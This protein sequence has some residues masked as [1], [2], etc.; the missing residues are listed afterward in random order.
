MGCFDH[1]YR[2]FGNLIVLKSSDRSCYKLFENC[3]V[4]CFAMSFTVGHALVLDSVLRPGAADCVLQS[5][6]SAL[7][8]INEEDFRAMA[9]FYNLLTRFFAKDH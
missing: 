1:A 2:A 9:A 7:Q 3:A 6:L 4:P 8:F 5:M